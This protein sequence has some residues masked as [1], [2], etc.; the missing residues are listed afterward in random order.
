VVDSPRGRPETARTMA[1]APDL[2]TGPGGR[3]ASEPEDD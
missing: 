3:V 2:E 1:V